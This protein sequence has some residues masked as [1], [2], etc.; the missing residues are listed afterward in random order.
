MKHKTFLSCV[1]SCCFL[2]LGGAAASADEL[3]VIDC[4]GNP[5]IVH[6]VPLGSRHT[7][8]A[9][10]IT[11]EG[12]PATDV[13]I[14]VVR[15]KDFAG[16]F[17]GARLASSRQALVRNG[18]A[19][20]ENISADPWVICVDEQSGGYL[21]GV[22]LESPPEAADTTPALKG[23]A[24]LGGVSLAGGVAAL[25]LGGSDNSSRDSENSLSDLS[26]STNGTISTGDLD[27]PADEVIG[28]AA[29]R[30]NIK[31]DRGDCFIGQ[32]TAPVSVFR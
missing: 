4:Q 5:K 15:E 28:S 10:V 29:S 32:T 8:I 11:S 25:T 19:R 31:D 17:D 16:G 30:P 14:V 13:E 26:G 24:L 3:T 20:F 23:A 12:M 2:T 6:D 7:L 1:F 9:D 21:A 22:R 18:K 27:G